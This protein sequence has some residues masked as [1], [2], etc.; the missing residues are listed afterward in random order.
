MERWTERLTG[1]GEIWPADIPSRW[2][3]AIDTA[4]RDSICAR[5][6][7]QDGGSRPV[8]RNR[9]RAIFPGK[10][11]PFHRSKREGSRSRSIGSSSILAGPRDPNL[12]GQDSEPLG[13]ALF[14]GCFIGL[15]EKSR[16]SACAWVQIS[17]FFEGRE[18]CIRIG[19]FRSRDEDAPNLVNDRA[20][21][22]PI[23]SSGKGWPILLHR[24]RQAF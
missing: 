6:A 12:Q 4:E 16:D 1:D 23:H 5:T 22:L 10:K 18:R 11:A 8:S 2:P 21:C 19:P 17:P 7:S 14:Y 24:S 9:K 13:S 15:L 3:L 20:A